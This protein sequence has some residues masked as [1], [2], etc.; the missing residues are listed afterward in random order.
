MKKKLGNCL[1]LSLTLAG[2]MGCGSSNLITSGVDPQGIESV[3]EPTPESVSLAIGDPVN[4][5]YTIEE[6]RGS[7]RYGVFVATDGTRL[8][9]TTNTQFQ[10]GIERLVKG[11]SYQITGQRRILAPNTVLVKGVAAHPDILL[12]ADFASDPATTG[13]IATGPSATWNAE[14]E[15][16]SVTQNSDYWISPYLES[17]LLQWYELTFDSLTTGIINNPGASGYGYW[18]VDY[19]HPDTG[20]RLP[21]SFVSSFFESS[22][23]SNRVYVRAQVAASPGGLIPANMQVSFRAIGNQ[24]FSIDNVVVRRAEDAEVLAWADDLYFNQIPAQLDYEPQD[25]RLVFLPQTLQRLQ[26]GD[27]IRVV[28]LGD[29]IVQDTGN[30]PLDLFLERIYPESTVELIVSTRGGTGVSFYKNNVQESILDYE[31]DLLVIGGISNGPDQDLEINYQSIIDQVRA[32]GLTEILIL[33]RAWSPSCQN[34]FFSPGVTELDLD[35]DNND[36]SQLSTLRGRLLQVANN[37]GIA[38]LDME[39]IS[40]EFIFGPALSIPYDYWMRDC[41][42]SN[43]FGKMIQGRELE[44]FFSL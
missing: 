33:S 29:S 17:E 32:A 37:N 22:E 31:P 23:T 5:T 3:S 9:V 18:R 26:N 19:F 44:L 28:M 30:S 14:A 35:L 36:P 7:N 39:G 2:L 10:E 13:W 11:Q 20:E 15:A 41:V 4:Q 25:N 24:P 12:S 40:S 1:T 21:G 34:P 27:R 38:F 6:D 16:L 42:H 8:R 43:D